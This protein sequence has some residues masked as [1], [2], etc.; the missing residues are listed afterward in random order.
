M[1]DCPFLLANILAETNDVSVRLHDAVR[2][3]LPVAPDWR[4]WRCSDY[5]VVANLSGPAIVLAPRDWASK[6]GA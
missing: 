1:P 3:F 2:I 5:V 4:Y 6:G